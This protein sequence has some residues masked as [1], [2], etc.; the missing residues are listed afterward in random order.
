MSC[1]RIILELSNLVEVTTGQ[2]WGVKPVQG[3]L[4][5]PGTCKFSPGPTIEKKRIQTVK[6]VQVKNS[7]HQKWRSEVV[8]RLKSDNFWLFW[9]PK[10]PEI[11]LNYFRTYSTVISGVN[12]SEKRLKQFTIH[13]SQSTITSLF[14]SLFCL[15]ASHNLGEFNN[16][17][18]KLSRCAF[19]LARGIPPCDLVYNRFVGQ[20]EIKDSRFKIIKIRKS[21]NHL[22]SKII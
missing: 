12:T 22:N 18:Y 13:S 7:Y 3:P 20:F 8:L 2:A 15:F 17:N 19:C 11:W 10:L 1:Q 9:L 14:C 21:S 16:S 5:L 4:N 6:A